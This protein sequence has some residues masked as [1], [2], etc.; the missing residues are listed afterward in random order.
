MMKFRTFINP[1]ENMQ[2]RID[3]GNISLYGQPL[4]LFPLSVSLH[5]LSDTRTPSFNNFWIN[6]NT[7]TRQHLHLLPFSVRPIVFS[8]TRTLSFFDRNLIIWLGP[9]TNITNILTHLLGP[10]AITSSSTLTSNLQTAARI[11]HCYP[12]WINLFTIPTPANTAN[13]TQAIDTV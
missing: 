11:F 3:K 7:L 8:V 13:I 4:Y 6:V 9:I 10:L 1:S 5:A 12:S 2:T